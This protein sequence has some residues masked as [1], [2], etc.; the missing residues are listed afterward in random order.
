[1]GTGAVSRYKLSRSKKFGMVQDL[2]CVQMRE[3]GCNGHYEFVLGAGAPA[4]RQAG[5]QKV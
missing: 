4:C 2:N 5:K 1:M 3:S